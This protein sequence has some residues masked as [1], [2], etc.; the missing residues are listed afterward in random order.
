MNQNSNKQT[1]IETIQACIDPGK[2]QNLSKQFI[3]S[4]FT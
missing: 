2:T 1:E 3:Y 4:K